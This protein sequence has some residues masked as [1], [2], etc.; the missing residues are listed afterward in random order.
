[1]TT[2]LDRPPAPAAT[3]RRPS[4]RGF[5]AVGFLATSAVVLGAMAGGKSFISTIPGAWFFGAPGGPLGSI[6]P[7]GGH[8][9]PVAMFGVYG[10]LLVLGATWWRLVGTL[11]AHRGVAVRQVLLV[12]AVWAV[13]LLLAP[14]LFSRDVFS[15]AGQ[16]EMVSHHI[17]PYL[18]GTGVLGATRFTSLAGPLWANTPSPYGPVFLALDG[19]VTTLAG[20]Q[21]LVVLVL[22]RLLAVA[23]VGLV[24]AGIPTLAR[25]AGRDPASAVVFGVG[26]PLVLAT[27]VAGDHNDALM[28]GLLVAGLAA[29]RRFGPLP[30]IVV[31]SLAA[32][33]KAPALLGVAFL[34]WNWA[35]PGSSVWRRVGRT[36]GAVAVSGVVLAAVSWWTGIGWGW[37]HT[38]AAESKVHTGVTPVDALARL[39]AVTADG[40]GLGWSM[41]TVRSVFAAAGLA[42]AA[43]AA[44]WLL[45]H[46]PRR[47][48]VRGLGWSLLLLA[49]LAP[50]LWG[51]YLVWGLV[52]LAPVVAGATRRALALF[53]VA[54]AMIGAAS[55]IGIL[56]TVAKTPLADDALL[57]VGMGVLAVACVRYRRPRP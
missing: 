40:L 24:A 25:A 11:D 50:V 8:P 46:S 53:T 41:G 51:W 16:G 18:Y 30:G 57:V 3:D 20:H 49:V 17:S 7:D 45:W 39:V 15:Y 19:L 13:P 4:L 54:E 32:G 47:G 38:L 10:G 12:V 35:G 42:V 31:C 5:A 2:L 27:L 6:P 37:V 55:V 29:A 44:A 56:R 48:L 36:A 26:S 22:L 1:M 33:V 52:V 43:G 23:G 28:A 21:V 34:G 9:A 14:P